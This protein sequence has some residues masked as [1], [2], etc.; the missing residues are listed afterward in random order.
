[1][2]LSKTKSGYPFESDQHYEERKEAFNRTYGIIDATPMS[3]RRSLRN[4]GAD[5]GAIEDEA[6]DRLFVSEQTLKASVLEG[7]AVLSRMAAT[8]A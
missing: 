5:S 1:M 2:S 4:P 6:H 3:I 7:E 8:P